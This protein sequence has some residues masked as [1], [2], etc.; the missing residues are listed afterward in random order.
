[1]VRLYAF[2]ITNMP[3]PKE[4]AAIIDKLSEKRREKVLRCS[5]LKGRKECAGAG[6]LLGEILKKYNISESEIYFG[7][8]GKPE[9]DKLH[10]NLSH[11]ENMVIC[12]VA[13]KEVGCDIEKTSK[14]PGR[15]AE[16]FFTGREK[17]HLEAVPK[18]KRNSEFFRIWTMKESY[19]KMTG[20]GMK[21]PFQSL[22][23]RLEDRIKIYRDKKEQNCFLREYELPGYRI[24][25]CSKDDTFSDV[26]E[27]IEYDENVFCPNN[28]Q[29]K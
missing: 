20:E 6:I 16:R 15:V 24:S 11:T 4:T 25:V 26:I 10:F 3:D 5:Q 2:N 28:V 1:M 21:V 23:I 27:I 12:A 19:I 8:N 7:D 17:A 29:H 13:N 9:T 22:E 18:E 14:A